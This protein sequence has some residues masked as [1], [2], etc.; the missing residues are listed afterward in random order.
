[1]PNENRDASVNQQ[2]PKSGG[3][4]LSGQSKGWVY[5]PTPSAQTYV[6]LL[7][8]FG[9]FNRN[10]R[11]PQRRNQHRHCLRF[12]H[13]GRAV[14]SDSI[15]AA[16]EKE[17]GD[18]GARKGSRLESR[19]AAMNAAPPPVLFAPL[20]VSQGASPASLST[21]HCT[22]ALG[23]RRARAGVHRGTIK[24]TRPKSSPPCRF[25][26]SPLATPG[27]LHGGQIRTSR[28]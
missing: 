21:R 12:D 18:Q 15:K 17:S 28:R 3:L 27:C 1:V 7:T 19:R 11:P 14:M 16:P 23:V 4:A 24:P 25:A 13:C 26:R 8:A 6:P 9:Y 2:C 22:S 5:T 20:P 10:G